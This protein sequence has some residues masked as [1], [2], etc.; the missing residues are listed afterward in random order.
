VDEGRIGVGFPVGMERYLY[1]DRLP[2]TRE[3]SH[4]RSTQTGCAAHGM[5]PPAG[6]LI[7]RFPGRKAAHVK[8]SEQCVE[9][10][11]G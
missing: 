5:S 8:L 7:G 1:L 2:E 4:N 3:L 6:K 10:N 11:L 9:M